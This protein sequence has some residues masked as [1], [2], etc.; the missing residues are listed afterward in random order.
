[1]R[2]RTQNIPSVDAGPPRRSPWSRGQLRLIPELRHFQPTDP[3]ARRWTDRFGPGWWLMIGA[4][5][6]LAVVLSL[7]WHVLALALFDPLT[8]SLHAGTRFELM[9]MGLVS[10]STLVVVLGA[11]FLGGRLAHRVR[12][13]VLRTE[14]RRRGIPICIACGY[15]GGDI[16][17]TR[18]PECGV[19]FAPKP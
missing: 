14:L 3:F 1:M 8:R 10:M 4:A 5:T 7:A 12:I 17:A 19:E 9:M 13:R 6:G 2:L 18:C 15:E 16:D 11:G